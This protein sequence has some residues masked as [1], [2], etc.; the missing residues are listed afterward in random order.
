MYGAAF[1]KMWASVDPESVKAAWAED[2]GPFS[3]QQIAWALQ[4]MKANRD[5]AF[6]YPP[7]MPKF[8]ALCQQAPRP[9]VAMLPSPKITLEQVQARAKQMGALKPQE[10]IRDHKK[11][12]REI[13]ADPKKYPAVSVRY[14]KE[15]LEMAE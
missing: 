8:R 5:G 1:S 3:G 10:Q 7:S 2:L 9:D 14:A 13:M 11:W 15:A 12:A 6:D 4:Q